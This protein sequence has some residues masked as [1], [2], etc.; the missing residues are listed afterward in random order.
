MIRFHDAR[1]GRTRVVLKPTELYV[2]KSE[3]TLTTVLG[4]CVAV[5]LWDPE[6]RITGMNHFV[7]SRRKDSASGF[8]EKEEGRFGEDA[9]PALLEQIE[10]AGAPR[11]R[12]TVKL[13]G[14]AMI[15]N[16]DCKNN[17][18][19]EEN[20][21]VARSFLSQRGMPIAAEDVGGTVGRRIHFDARTG[22]VEVER[23]TRYNSTLANDP[24]KGPSKEPSSPFQKIIY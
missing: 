22:R 23:L 6:T 5:C 17:C 13:F 24:L 2:S 10:R 12:L 14:G 15:I 4:S 1:T 3:E 7:L 19:G 18:V 11:F 16:K 21:K 20:I 8:P 9:M